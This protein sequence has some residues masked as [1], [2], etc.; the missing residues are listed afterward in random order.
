MKRLCPTKTPVTGTVS[1]LKT[2]QTN[3]QTKHQS[4]VQHNNNLYSWNKNE[5]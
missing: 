2:P 5:K 3:E 4:A 1:S